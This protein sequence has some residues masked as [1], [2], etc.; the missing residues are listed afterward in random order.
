MHKASCCLGEVSEC[1]S[2]SYVTFQGHMN[3]KIIEFERNWAFP[4]YNSCLKFHQ[5]LRNDAHSLKWHRW[6]DL[7]F[8]SVICQIARPHGTNKSS[9]LTQMGVFKLQLQLEFTDGYEM[10]KKAWSTIEELPCYFSRSFVKFHGHMG[11]KISSLNSP[12]ALKL[13]TKLNRV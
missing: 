10:M 1:I 6:G 7:Y 4:D 5:N 13:C 3:T 9:I 12:M 11:R 2:M 8:S